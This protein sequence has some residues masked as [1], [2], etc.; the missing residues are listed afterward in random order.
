MKTHLQ[1]DDLS[2]NKLPS[3]DLE[4]VQEERKYARRRDLDTEPHRVITIKDRQQILNLVSFLLNA[5][6]RPQPPTK[7]P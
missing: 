7:T 2:V 4:L 1:L 5:Y 6:A 3:G